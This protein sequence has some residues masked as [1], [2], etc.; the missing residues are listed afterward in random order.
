MDFFT[1]RGDLFTWGWNNYGQLGLGHTHSRDQPHRV[2][3][4]QRAV[5]VY[6]GDWTTVVRVEKLYGDAQ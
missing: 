2:E 5:G 4:D 1:D 3:L 6:A